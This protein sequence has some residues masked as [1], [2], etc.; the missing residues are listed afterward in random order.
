ML[1]AWS[2]RVAGSLL[3]GTCVLGACGGRSVSVTG[4][5][6]APG[7]GGTSATTGGA[8]AA[9]TGGTDASCEPGRK[10][11]RELRDALIEKYSS[12]GCKTEADCGL[13]VENNACALGCPLSLPSST[14]DDYSRNLNDAASAC[15]ACPPPEG[16]DCPSTS[17]AC[18]NG[19]CVAHHPR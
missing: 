19:A 18:S 15:W 16:P 4:H 9:S 2:L 5:D 6:D 11:Y 12:L 7:T 3:L 13:V 14:I 10:A 1:R 8:T 17:S